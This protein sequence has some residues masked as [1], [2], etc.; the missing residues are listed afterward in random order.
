MILGVEFA[1]S[2]VS[3]SKRTEILFS[4]FMDLGEKHDFVEACQVV[5]KALS[6]ARVRMAE[7]VLEN[8]KNETYMKK[9]EAMMICNKEKDAKIKAMAQ[10]LE[11]MKERVEKMESSTNTNL[12]GSSSGQKMAF[13]MEGFRASLKWNGICEDAIEKIVQSL[14]KGQK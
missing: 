9:D 12:A 14:E 5:E 3:L 6:S 4:D 1:Q 11:E 2:E 7:S 13:D 8:E 10:E